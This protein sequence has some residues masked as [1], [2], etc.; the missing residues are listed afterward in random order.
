M[1]PHRARTIERMHSQEVVL[2]I[3]DGSTL[4]Y[5][6]RP[7]CEGLD[8]I[9]RNQTATRTRGMHIHVTLATTNRGLPL[10]VLRCSYTDPTE[11]PLKPKAQQRHGRVHLRARARADRRL[12]KD[13]K[14]FETMSG[15]KAAKQV[16][17][18]IRRRSARPKASGRSFRRAEAEIRFRQVTLPATPLVPG[19]D[20]VTLSAVHVKETAP[21][22]GEE[23]AE[24]YLLTSLKVKTAEE[25]EQIMEYYRKRWRIEEFFRV[26][27]SGCKV[28]QRTHRTALRLQRSL[29]IYLVIA[30]LLMV[31]TLLGREARMRAYSL[32]KRSFNS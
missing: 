25:A 32:P 15:G 23:A 24:W 27:K 16:K 22:P 5:A 8:V 13:R 2:C 3:Q 19:A 6:S 26:L 7:A 4:N 11:G 10:G 9:G 21:P 12:S 31:L 30:W 1:A 18:N 17:I 20:P 14:L 28:E 29:A